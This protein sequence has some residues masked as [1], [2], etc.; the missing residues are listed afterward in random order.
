VTGDTTAFLDEWPLA[1]K[2]NALPSNIWQLAKSYTQLRQ[3]R[4]IKPSQQTLA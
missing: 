1:K 4:K 3:S 2:R